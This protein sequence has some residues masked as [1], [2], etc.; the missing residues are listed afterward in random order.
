M[1]V[2]IYVN[3]YL[4]TMVGFMAMNYFYEGKSDVLS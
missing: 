2:F 3:H 4:N 1:I